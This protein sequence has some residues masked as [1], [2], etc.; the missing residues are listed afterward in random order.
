MAK[1]L[2]KEKEPKKV[3]K[4]TAKKSKAKKARKEAAKPTFWILP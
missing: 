2:I 1:E 3:K 4:Q